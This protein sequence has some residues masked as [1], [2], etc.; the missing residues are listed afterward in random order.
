MFQL[1]VSIRNS[2]NIY[3]F[4]LKTNSDERPENEMLLSTY[5]F[6]VF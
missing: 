5:K 4:K 2:C 3:S 1:D 6:D